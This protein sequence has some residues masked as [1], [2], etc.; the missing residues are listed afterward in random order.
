VGGDRTG[1]PINWVLT[2]HSRAVVI[3]KGGREKIKGG[4]REGEYRGSE[5]K[6]MLWVFFRG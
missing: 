2:L 1:R 6:L 3:A 5:M 4:Q